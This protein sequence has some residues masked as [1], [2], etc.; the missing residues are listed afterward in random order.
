M[1]AA[2]N[3]FR[4]LAGSTDIKIGYEKGG[5]RLAA[6]S[7][8]NWANNPSNGKSTSCYILMFPSAPRLVFKSLQPCPQWKLS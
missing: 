3:I 5:F 6:F 7:D 2:E 4:Y 8:F 1:V